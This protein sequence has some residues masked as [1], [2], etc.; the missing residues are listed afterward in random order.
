M[1]TKKVQMKGGVRMAEA[2]PTWLKQPGDIA[3]FGLGLTLVF[4]GLTQ[5]STGM[6][7]L[8]KGVGKKE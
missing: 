3:V 8:A 6:Y 1:A 2:N 5:L 7:R 4:A